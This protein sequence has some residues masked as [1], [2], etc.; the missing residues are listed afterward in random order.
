MRVSE[1]LAQVAIL[2]KDTTHAGNIGAAARAMKV[3]GLSQLKLVAARTAINDTAKAMATAAAEDVL[4][5]AAQHDTLQSALADF[6]HTYAFSARRR[7][8]SP[9]TLTPRAAAAEAIT[10]V[11]EGGRVAF[12]FGGETSGLEN[13]DI[14]TATAIVEIPTAPDCSSLNLAQAV[15]LACYEL[16]L[17]TGIQPAATPREMPTQSE[18]EAMLAHMEEALTAVGL[19]KKNDTRPLIPRMRRLL[20]RAEPDASEVRLLRGIWRAMLRK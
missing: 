10:R 18:F 4:D 17:A 1:Q 20:T 5:A 6:T 3:M 12:L 16:R 13:E 11:Q 19:P 9:R 8:M 14:L 15:Q 2:L 7:G